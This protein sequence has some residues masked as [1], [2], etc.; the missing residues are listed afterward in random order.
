ML[1]KSSL[2]TNQYKDL[3]KRRKREERG[4][5]SEDEEEVEGDGEESVDM[6][7]DQE[8]EIIKKRN[9]DLEQ[10]EEDTN[11]TDNEDEDDHYLHTKNKAIQEVHEVVERTNDPFKEYILM[12]PEKVKRVLFER[13]GTA[14][15]KSKY[16]T[17][18]IQ[19]PP[20]KTVNRKGIKTN[21]E[22][23]SIDPSINGLKMEVRHFFRSERDLLSSGYSTLEDDN[24][25]T[26]LLGIEKHKKGKHDRDLSF[27]SGIT[28]SLTAIRETKRQLPYMGTF[29]TREVRQNW[30]PN[31]RRISSQLASIWTS[32]MSY[33]DVLY[34]L[35]SREDENLRSAVNDY[36]SDN[37]YDKDKTNKVA[38][39]DTSQYQWPI[40]ELYCL[41]ALNHTI[42]ARQRVIKRNVNIKRLKALHRLKQRDD[43]VKKALQKEQNVVDEED[44]EKGQ[45]IEEV[46]IENESEGDLIKDDIDDDDEEDEEEEAE[47]EEDERDQGFTRPKVLILVPMRN[48]AYQVVQT[49]LSLLGPKTA[50]SGMERLREDYGP[51]EDEGGDE[52]ENGE[53]SESKYKTTKP[54]D[55]KQ[56]FTGN[57]DDDVKLGISITPGKGIGKGKHKGCRLQL[58]TDFYHSDII[59]ASPLGLK[60]VMSTMNGN[61]NEEDENFVALHQV[62][63]NTSNGLDFLSSLEIVIVEQAD[64]ILMQ[65]WTHLS[66]VLSSCNQAPKRDNNTDFSRVY[67]HLLEGLAPQYR[68]LLLFSRFTDPSITALYNKFASSHAGSIRLSRSISDNSA[69]ICSVYSGIQQVFKEIATTSLRTKDDEKFDYFIK[70]V[71]PPLLKPTAQKHTMIFIPSY[72][73]FVRLRNYFIKRKISHACISEYERP[74]EVSRSRTRFFQGRRP[75]L[76][77]TGR[78]HFYK[79]YKIRGVS[80]L[81]FYS[82]PEYA[83]YYS[84]LT[85]LVENQDKNNKSPMASMT[86]MNTSCLALYSPYD[87]AALQRVVGEK[88][89]THMLEAEKN[90]FL[91]C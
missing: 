90:T 42:K 36:S 55:W 54:A 25:T 66:E 47:A 89:S 49:L 32:V 84:E 18:T 4:E 46:V 29:L 10:G 68:Q 2:S 15:A 62:K 76:L 30:T 23:Q 21:D 33:Q 19:L 14:A 64:I 73:D 52:E 12:E 50:V 7:N 26:P 9:L 60:L 6:V 28:N 82:L 83:H 71:L 48:T 59:L 58:Y 40:R 17:S 74:N 53:E 65:N 77:Y 5:S 35:L 61:S 20:R 80:H 34:P 88:R 44:D 91:F 13:Y 22:G 69:S 70:K 79:R 86:T 87:V 45:S 11:V 63:E 27:K 67:L 3:I 51:E 78:A 1:S 41:H 72:F 16:E 57:V 56:A 75:F 24:I 39:S 37:I 85:N 38:K 43:G 81:I 8:E 31:P